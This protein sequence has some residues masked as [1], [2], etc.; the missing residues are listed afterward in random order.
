MKQ[1]VLQSDIDNKVITT[2]KTQWKDV[3]GE[4]EFVLAVGRNSGATYLVKWVGGSA[5]LM[6]PEFWGVSGK[7]FDTLW[8]MQGFFD[9]YT[10][11]SLTE[12]ES[13]MEER[14]LVWGRGCN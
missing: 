2:T 3:I 12:I 6:N 13:F 5:F 4:L 10:F 8:E 11:S 9:L 7:E 14:G 1:L